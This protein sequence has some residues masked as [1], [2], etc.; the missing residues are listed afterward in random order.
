MK[1]MWFESHK[2]MSNESYATHV[3]LCCVLWSSVF[4]RDVVVFGHL[5]SCGFAVLLSISMLCVL[6]VVLL[7]CCGVCCLVWCLYH[8]VCMWQMHQWC[9]QCCRSVCSDNVTTNISLFFPSSASTINIWYLISD[10]VTTNISLF[11][12][13]FASTINIWYLISDNVSTNIFLFF[14]SSASTINS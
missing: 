12:P 14:P 5:L 9:L 2:F 11:F 4:S 13:S 8:V 10:N 3:V 1:A 7:L 6:C